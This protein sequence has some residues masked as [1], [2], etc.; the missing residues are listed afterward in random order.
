MRQSKTVFD[1]LVQGFEDIENWRKGNLALKTTR[2]PLP[3]SP[4]I[5]SG[6]EIFLLRRELKMSQGY[7]SRL[8]GVSAKT[9]QGWEQ[10]LRKPNA[11]ALRLLQIIQ[12]K[13]EV[14][15]FLVAGTKE[16]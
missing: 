13:P 8:L 10:G 3:D 5:F 14:V 12:T 11:S 6:Q 4:P 7:F 2:Y 9:V 1:D 16:K 15:D